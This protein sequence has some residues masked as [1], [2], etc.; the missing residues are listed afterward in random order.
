MLREMCK[1]KIHRATVTETN[2]HYEGSLTLDAELME[3]ADLV[4]YEKVQILNVNNGIRATTY[5]TA[6][7]RGSGT[8]CLNGPAA[9]S[10][11]PGDIVIIISYI[12]LSEEELKKYQP[13]IVQVDS[14]NRVLST[15]TES[16]PARRGESNLVSETP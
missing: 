1:S 3:A 14:K 5:V 16:S 6:G 4:A 11:Q 10:G 7:E 9:R 12:L 8:V 2:L 13:R 15:K